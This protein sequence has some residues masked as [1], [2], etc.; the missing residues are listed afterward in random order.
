VTVSIVSD[1]AVLFGA[2][3]FNL[4][5]SENLLGAEAL[6]RIT[7]KQDS[8]GTPAFALAA[9]TDGFAIDASTGAITTTAELDR[10][11]SPV[12]ELQATVRMQETPNEVDT[13]TVFVALTDINDNAPEFVETTFYALVPE[14]V[15][16]GA[17]VTTIVAFDLDDGDNG[18]VHY[19]FSTASTDFAIDGDSGIVISNGGFDV[20]DAL[21]PGHTLLVQATDGGSPSLSSTVNLVVAIVDVNDNAPTFATGSLTLKRRENVTVGTVLTTFAAT[22]KDRTLVNRRIRYSLVGTNLPVTIDPTSGQLKLATPL[23]FETK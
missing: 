3:S 19:A 7:L 15:V 8:T 2:R 12:I 20:D 22:D 5:V 6:P 14:N 13:V 11:A 1:D 10:E 4:Q 21:V 17:D 23:D 16:A 18:K 9:A